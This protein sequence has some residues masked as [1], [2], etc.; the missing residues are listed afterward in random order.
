MSSTSA[1]LSSVLYDQMQGWFRYIPGGNK[2]FPLPG[3]KELLSVRCSRSRIL[4][5][6]L[7]SLFCLLHPLFINPFRSLCMQFEIWIILHRQWNGFHIGALFHTTKN[8]LKRI[9][10]IPT[11]IFKRFAYVF[12]L[13]LI[14]ASDLIIPFTFD[15][16]CYQPLKLYSRLLSNFIIIPLVFGYSYKRRSNPLNYNSALTLQGA[17]NKS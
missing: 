13:Q 15:L 5:F 17:K 8:L 4:F 14:K 11:F 16:V 3:R 9:T 2:A 6:Q 7:R 1:C 10:L 12:I